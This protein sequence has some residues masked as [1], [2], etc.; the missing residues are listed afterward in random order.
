[1]SIHSRDVS[2]VEGY[3]N[4]YS[5]L[6]NL[7]VKV[8]IHDIH[9][10]KYMPGMLVQVITNALVYQSCY[11]GAFWHHH[12]RQNEVVAWDIGIVIT[13]TKP[14]MSGVSWGALVLF[15]GSDVMGWVYT[16]DLTPI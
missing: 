6:D 2:Y 15:C 13:C 8:H 3:S 12:H 14:D 11:N 9:V 10:G 5:R 4:S 7:G 1:M 16:K